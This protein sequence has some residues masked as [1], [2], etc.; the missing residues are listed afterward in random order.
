[1]ANQYVNKVVQSN[2]TTLIDITDTTAQASDVAE[3]KYF[4]AANG[5]KMSGTAVHG[6]T[7]ATVVTVETLPNGADHYIIN[8]VD[9]SD[10]T[11]VA[12]DVSQGKYFYTSSGIKTEGTAS[13][14]MSLD[15]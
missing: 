7:P 13:G 2:G 5:Q 14:G 1:M 8:G 9:I 10:T 12:A 6:S 4:Y 3:G 15:N 11:A